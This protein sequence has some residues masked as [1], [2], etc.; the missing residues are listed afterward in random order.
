MSKGE[1]SDGNA[2]VIHR[3]DTHMVLVYF[4]FQL[5]T[6]LKMSNFTRNKLYNNF[7]KL[8][9][10]LPIFCNIFKTYYETAKKIPTVLS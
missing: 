5:L 3:G 6:T 7:Y 2:E 4:G 9:T 1:S 8:R 10:W